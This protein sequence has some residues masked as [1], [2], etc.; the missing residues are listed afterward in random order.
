MTEYA[1]IYNISRLEFFVTSPAKPY[2]SM[3]MPQLGVL[4]VLRL[5]NNIIFAE[6]GD[7]ESWKEITKL[8]W[9]I[10]SSTSTRNLTLS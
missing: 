3:S 8:L 9:I 2:D 5:H 4:K 7:E 10:S 6:F 1:N